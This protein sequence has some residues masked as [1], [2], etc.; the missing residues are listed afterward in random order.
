MKNKMLIIGLVTV[1]LLV[2]YLFWAHHRIYQGISH[3]NLPASD[4]DHE[5]LVGSSQ[6][7]LVY[8][9]IGDS[10]TA[11][12]GV[13]NYHDSYAYQL[14]EDFAS[15]SGAAI[16][17]HVQAYPGARTADAVRDF[18]NPA[19]GNQPDIVTILLG[20]NDIHG[21]VSAAEFTN[22]YNEIITRLKAETKAKIYAISIPYLGTKYTVL[23]PYDYY[24]RYQT[25]RFNNIIKRLAAVN[26]IEYIDLYAP[27]RDMFG[28]PTLYSADFFHPSASEYR[29]WAQTIYADINN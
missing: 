3:A 14:T 16:D 10:L 4:I 25:I 18:L 13:K 15:T 21:F 17:L 5:Y 26:N 6:A 12:V 23:P 7:K 24:L 20:V 29:V 22:N 28:N 11:G 8:T 1:A 19:I 9:A 27:T 2:A